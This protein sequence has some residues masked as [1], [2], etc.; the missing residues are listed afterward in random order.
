MARSPISSPS[1]SKVTPNGGSSRSG[2]LRG[3]IGE[4]EQP[5]PLISPKGAHCAAAT[6]RGHRSGESSR[7][8]TRRVNDQGG[9]DAAA[10]HSAGYEEREGGGL[11]ARVNAD[12]SA[13]AYGPHDGLEQQYRR[14]YGEARPPP[15]RNTP[16]Q[17]PRRARLEN[18]WHDRE[19]DDALRMKG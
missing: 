18:S 13:V 1:S 14:E 17:F 2:L 19:A 15:G 3:S 11:G 16:N 6:Q 12:G 10:H 4:V 8:R 5:D 9:D 7:S